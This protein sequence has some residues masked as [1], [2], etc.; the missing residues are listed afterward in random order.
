MQHYINTIKRRVD[1]YKNKSYP[2]VQ[3]SNLLKTLNF[4]QTLPFSNSVNM[5][6]E[7][8][9]DALENLAVAERVNT[10]YFIDECIEKIGNV[11][12]RY[13][14]D[15]WGDKDCEERFH[16][17]RQDKIERIMTAISCVEKSMEIYKRYESRLPQ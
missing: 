13:E 11:L 3:Y 1:V 8:V 7:Y 16:L 6:I 4:L 14:S 17:Q 15:D 5:D 10:K 12:L 9:N 2:R